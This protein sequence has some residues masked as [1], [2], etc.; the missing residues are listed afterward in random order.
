MGITEITALVENYGI[1]GAIF[2]LFIFSISKIVK[3]EWFDNI[4]TKISE[5]FIERF[6]KN[7]RTGSDSI[8]N[9]SESDIIN[10]DF[11]NYINFWMYSKVPTL[12]FS[13]EYRTAVFRKYLSLY[14]K[15]YKENLSKFIESG[16]YKDM[17]R[18]SLNNALLDLVNNIIYDYE[19]HS[20]EAGIPPI[21]IEKMKVSNNNTITLLISLIDSICSNQFYYSENNLLIIYSLLNITHSILDG[22]ISNSEIVCNSINGQLKGLVFEGKK[23]K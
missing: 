20:R 14:L 6:I 9:I 12:E 13:S 17:D 11:F 21:I 5:K 8:D 23:E 19:R 18:P 7:K 4:V 22:T 3:S 16:E 10:H 15:S 2:V 1:S